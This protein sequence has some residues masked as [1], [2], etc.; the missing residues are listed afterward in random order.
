MG[1]LLTRVWL[2][3]GAIIRDS[4]PDYVSCWKLFY[5]LLCLLFLRTAQSTL[6]VKLMHMR[7]SLAKKERTS[8]LC[9]PFLRLCVQTNM[10]SSLVLNLLLRFKLQPTSVFRLVHVLSTVTAVDCSKKWLIAQTNPVLKLSCLNSSFCFFSSVITALCEG[11]AAMLGAAETFS[12]KPISGAIYFRASGLTVPPV[13][14]GVI[15]NTVVW[16]KYHIIILY[17]K[18]FPKKTKPLMRL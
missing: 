7:L 11:L 2:E 9:P 15:P 12:C 18:A 8:Q 3:T 10:E 16:E 4:I 6:R 13:E 5:H 14:D 17:A 1:D